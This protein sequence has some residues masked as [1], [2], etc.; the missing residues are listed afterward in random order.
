MET[1]SIIKRYTDPD[2]YDGLKIIHAGLHRT[3]SSSLSV[4][5][6]MLG[7]GPCY[8]GVTFS[9]NYP[10]RFSDAIDWFIDN[11]I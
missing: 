2:K 3:G 6:D 10:Q 7:F 11:Q 4:A 8:H 9:I 1:P 5:L